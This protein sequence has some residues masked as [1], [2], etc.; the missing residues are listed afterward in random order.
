M[1]K[2]IAT[3]LTKRVLIVD[4]DTY[5]RD[6]VR[7][8]L[9]EQDYLHIEI[10]ESADVNSAIQQMRNIHQDI[11]ILDL[12]MP[13][14]DGFDFMEIMHQNKRFATT[15]VI[16]LSADSSIDNIFKAEKRGIG[17]YRFLSKPFNICDLQALVFRL[18]LPIKT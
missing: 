8:A 14:K 6:A 16:M 9:E 11:V 18:S 10:T 12:H 3:R 2:Q 5:S 1:P 17:V 15:E 4:D 13:G 7:L